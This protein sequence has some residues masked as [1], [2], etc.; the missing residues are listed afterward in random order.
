M[1][2]KNAKK[3]RFTLVLN[4]IVTESNSNDITL[5]L[6]HQIH[7]QPIMSCTRK[8]PLRPATTLPAIQLRNPATTIHELRVPGSGY[9]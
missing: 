6:L 4:K 3:K 2:V 8:I 5:Q 7:H 9:D 1:I